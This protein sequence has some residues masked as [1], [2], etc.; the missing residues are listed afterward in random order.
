MPVR[1][2]DIA[3]TL[4]ITSKEVIARAKDLGI[5]NAKV[6]SSSLDKITAEFLEKKIGGNSEPETAP[7]PEESKKS[8]GIVIVSAPEEPIEEEPAEEPTAEESEDSA[9]EENVAADSTETDSK[10]D[11]DEEESGPLKGTVRLH[12]NHRGRYVCFVDGDGAKAKYQAGAQKP[13][14]APYIRAFS[15]DE[16]FGEIAVL[17]LKV[18]ANGMHSLI[19]DGDARGATPVNAVDVSQVATALE[20]LCTGSATKFMRA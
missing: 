20:E 2:Y 16:D 1:I 4:G 15:D 17:L 19:E 5:A 14:E 13:G 11:A 9:D 3:K 8:E 7:A 6:P 12:I 10:V 18:Q